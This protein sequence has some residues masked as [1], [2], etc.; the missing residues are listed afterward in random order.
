MS[1]SVTDSS[2][3]DSS[4]ASAEHAPTEMQKSDRMTGRRQDCVMFMKCSL[5]P[6]AFEKHPASTRSPS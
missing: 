5:F 4:V 2:V 1:S 6:M 3:T